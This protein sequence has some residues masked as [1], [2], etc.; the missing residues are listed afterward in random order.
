MLNNNKSKKKKTEYFQPGITFFLQSS[1]FSFQ[2]QLLFFVL[3]C[4]SGAMFDDNVCRRRIF[5]I[6]KH[7]NDDGKTLRESRREKT[8]S[9]KH[10]IETKKKWA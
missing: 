8:F 7:L 1:R 6:E 4:Q 9:K 2:F 3:S 10:K 5:R